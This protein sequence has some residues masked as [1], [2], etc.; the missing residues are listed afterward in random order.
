MGW[1][2]LG[3]ALGHLDLCKVWDLRRTSLCWLRSSRQQVLQTVTQ[4]PYF[5]TA[6]LFYRFGTFGMFGTG[7]W[8]AFECKCPHF[9]FINLNW[10]A[11]TNVT[12][13][14][15]ISVVHKCFITAAWFEKKYIVNE[16][17]WLF[18]WTYTDSLI[19]KNS[20][21][22]RKLKNVGDT[23]PRIQKAG[24]VFEPKRL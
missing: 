20:P 19:K 23:S 11:P 2:Q 22:E 21:I 15:P 4:C 24:C 12:W 16:A 10:I 1:S 8:C 17:M 14:Q 18:I 6:S 3:F 13:R 9:G 5:H 7:R